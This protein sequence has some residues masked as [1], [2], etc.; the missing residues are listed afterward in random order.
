MALIHGD[1]WASF[2]AVRCSEL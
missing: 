2:A 1:I